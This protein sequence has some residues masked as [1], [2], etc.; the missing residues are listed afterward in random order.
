M[1]QA[2]APVWRRVIVG[3]FYRR[4]MAGGDFSVIRSNW[5]GPRLEAC[6]LVENERIDRCRCRRQR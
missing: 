4:D 5:T 2:M 1:S 3:G 6:G